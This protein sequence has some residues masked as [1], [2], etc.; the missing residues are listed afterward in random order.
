MYIFMYT[1]KIER[2]SS[3][4]TIYSNKRLNN[5]RLYNISVASTDSC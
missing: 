3:F 1:L 2:Y 4:P 5:R